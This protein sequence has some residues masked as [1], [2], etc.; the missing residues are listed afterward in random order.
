MRPVTRSGTVALQP[1]IYSGD[2]KNSLAAVSP[3]QPFNC[4]SPVRLHWL[5]PGTYKFAVVGR[6][7][8]GNVAAPVEHSWAV[9][10]AQGLLYTRFLG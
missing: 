5:L 1:A 7:P 8:A 10:Y 6:D 2:S 9:A 3:G 4:T